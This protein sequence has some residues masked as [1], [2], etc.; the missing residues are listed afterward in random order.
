MRVG[1]GSGQSKRSEVVSGLSAGRG[2]A[3]KEQFPAHQ[4]A[5]S[6]V[7]QIS[8]SHASPLTRLRF[9]NKL[10]IKRGERQAESIYQMIRDSCHLRPASKVFVACPLTATF[11][12]KTGLPRTSTHSV[13]CKRQ[14]ARRRASLML[15]KKHHGSCTGR[16]PIEMKE[17]F[18]F[19]VKSIE[20]DRT[21]VLCP[22]ALQNRVSC[23][24]PL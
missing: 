3:S 20:V 14:V 10:D 17:F 24:D 6:N 5:Q 9:A 12:A 23:A 22:G 21:K 15:R 13:S 18:H 1:G 16:L 4:H 8:C 19:D 11:A 2:D 7:T